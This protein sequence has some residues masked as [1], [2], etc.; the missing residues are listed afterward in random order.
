M[1]DIWKIVHQERGALIEDL[2]RVPAPQWSTE[3]LC[4]GWDV[5]DVLAHLVDDAK[6]TKLSL[7]GSMIRARFN[8]DRVNEIG[9]AANKHPDPTQTLAEFT[10]VKDRT[11]SAPA[12]LTTRLVEII[13]HGEDI[14]RPLGLNH[15]YP[16]EAVIKALQYQLKTGVSM[17]GGKERA[18]GLRLVTTDGAFSHGEGQEVGGNALSL[19]LA[20]SGRPVGASEFSG[21]GAKNLIASK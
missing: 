6:S 8:F 3:S 5:H 2:S 20:V 21:D 15:S 1:A 4:P 11:S 10:L 7:I 9:I 17:G 12:P 14:R 13:V 18:S 19:L 16:I